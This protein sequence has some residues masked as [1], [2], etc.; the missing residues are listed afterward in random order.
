MSKILFDN[1]IGARTPQTN[2][3]EMSDPIRPVL[4]YSDS[5]RDVDVCPDCWDRLTASARLVFAGVDEVFTWDFAPEHVHC[6]ICR[7]VLRTTDADKFSI[8]QSLRY[9][10]LKAYDIG[11]ACALFPYAYTPKDL[12]LAL[13]EQLDFSL[14]FAST[15]VRA[16]YSVDIDQNSD[17]QS[18]KRPRQ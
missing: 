4:V 14:E 18:S 16:A 5:E 8:T 11:R 13:M 15:V 2:P 12:L 1:E 3:V 7:R 17:D 9:S 6:D 10:G